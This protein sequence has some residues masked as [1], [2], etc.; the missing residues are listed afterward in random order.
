MK[1]LCFGMQI[2]G[3]GFSNSDVMRM[4]GVYDVVAM[5]EVVLFVVFSV[6]INKKSLVLF[7]FLFYIFLYIIIYIYRYISVFKFLH[8]AVSLFGLFKCLLYY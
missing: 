2:R 7:Y 4:M 5:T 8:Y 3:N 6:S 1:T